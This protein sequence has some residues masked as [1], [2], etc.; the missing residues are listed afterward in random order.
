MKASQFSLNV[1]RT[2]L[3]SN[4]NFSSMR[5]LKVEDLPFLGDS[6]FVYPDQYGNKF[7]ACELFNSLELYN[8]SF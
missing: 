2:Y 1:G 3:P 7:K 8:S 6:E 4:K 5:L